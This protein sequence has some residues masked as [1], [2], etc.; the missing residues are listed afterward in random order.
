MNHTFKQKQGENTIHKKV[1]ENKD[2]KQK[3]DTWDRS[4][5]TV[6]CK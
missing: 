6:E 2:I 5:L 4:T 3:Y 1:E